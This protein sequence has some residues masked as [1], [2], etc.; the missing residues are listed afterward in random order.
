MKKKFLYIGLALIVAA[1]A[2]LLIA[3]SVLTSAVSG[4]FN[5]K[6]VSIGSMS[7]S[8][9]PITIT[10]NS[11]LFG[12]VGSDRP[13]NFYL[14]NSSGFGRWSSD[15][16][17]SNTPTGYRF[18]ISLEGNGLIYG[19]HDTVSGT[20]PYSSGIG[21]RTPFYQTNITHAMPGTYYA[22]V[23]NTNGSASSNTSI[24]ATVV[25]PSG[26]SYTSNAG[27]AIGIIAAGFGFFIMLIAGIAFIAY[28]FWKKTPVVTT[29]GQPSM[30]K[31]QQSKKEATDMTSEQVDQLYKS[32]K[33]KSKQGK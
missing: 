22:V 31:T 20:F 28:G 30:Q 9:V 10:S 29:E 16:G 18:A 7:F 12:G 32:I 6:N 15:M 23:D 8:S 2:V 4:L 19:Y 21:N 17:S 11:L 24:K 1:F 27:S 5:Q 25:Y 33:K 13:I 3:G 26:A 14:F